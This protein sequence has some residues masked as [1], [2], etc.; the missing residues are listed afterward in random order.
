M[1]DFPIAL[2]GAELVLVDEQDAAE[3]YAVVD[4]ERA[5]LRPFLPWIGQA[6]D[7]T[8]VAAHLRDARLR[9]DRGEGLECGLRVEGR[10]VGGV[11][12]HHVDLRNRSGEVGYWLARSAQGRGLMTRAVAAVTRYAFETGFHRLEIRMWPGNPKSRRVAERLGYVRE[13]VL[14]EAGWHPDGWRDLEVW[15]MLAPGER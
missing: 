15:A 6:T 1:S 2:E 8:F 5:H 10:L 3:V 9:R 11:G 14:Q 12:V 7:A 4:A 13:G